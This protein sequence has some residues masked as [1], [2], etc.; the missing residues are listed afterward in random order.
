M[1]SDKLSPLSFT[2]PI[3]AKQAIAALDRFVMCDARGDAA[4]HKGSCAG[5]SV[6]SERYHQTA[7]NWFGKAEAA[8]AILRAFLVQEA[9]K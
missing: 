2:K 1:T 5:G 9:S 6:T 7:A 4:D 3:T 8:M